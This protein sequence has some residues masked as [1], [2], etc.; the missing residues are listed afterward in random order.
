MLARAA[1]L[2][3][4]IYA[5]APTGCCLHIVL[6][7]RNE[8]DASVR[9]CLDHARDRAAIDPQHAQCVELA[10]LLLGMTPAERHDLRVAP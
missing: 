1:A 5:R 8:D 9:H 10:A 7:D 3:R 2:A 4:D 6:D